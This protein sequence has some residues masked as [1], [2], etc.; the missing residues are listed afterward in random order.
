MNGKTAATN[1]ALL[2]GAVSFGLLACE[3]GARLL[4][5]PADYLSVRMVPDKILG[6]VLPGTAA[7]GFDKWGFRNLTVPEHADVVAIGDSHTYGNTAKMEDS[8]PKVLERLTG[9]T[10]YN[11]G[12]GGYGPNQYFY[13]LETK[14]LQLKPRLVI[15]GLYLGDDFENAYTITYGLDHWAYLRRFPSGEVN[16]DIWAIPANPSWHK[17]IR[18]WLS[19]HSVVYQLLFHASF[20]GN[21]Q[22]EVQI[23][24][25]PEVN[26]S[27]TSLIIPEQNI[28]EAFLPKSILA[29][30]DQQNPNVLEG[31]RITFELLKAMN[32]LCAQNHA[33]F[34]VVII[35]TKE[36]VFSDYLENNSSLPLSDV[37]HKLIFNERLALDKTFQVL[38]NSNI[39]YVDTLPLLRRSVHQQLYARTAAD[40]HPGKNGYRVI[41]EAISEYLHQHRTDAPLAGVHNAN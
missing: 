35:P 1:V 20:I 12:M 2:V 37:L 36:M 33:K 31:M 11:M 13:L 14:A 29:R 28:L 3:F 40:M 26:S 7:R 22:G 19:E 16:P 6:A 41:A 30:L 10:V 27:A 24:T 32:D 9:Q 21:L 23:K 25:A 39:R 4:L 15:C 18:V 8:W 34:L 5:N 17:S 38:D